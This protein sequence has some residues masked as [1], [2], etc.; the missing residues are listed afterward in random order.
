MVGKI[1]RARQK[2]HAAAVKVDSSAENV[3]ISPDYELPGAAELSVPPSWSKPV[4][5]KDWTSFSSD[6]FASTKIDP[7]ILTQNLEVETKS[8]PPI[9]K[10]EK[11]I[12]PKKEKAKQRRERWLEKIESLKLAQVAKKAQAKRKATPIVGDLQALVDALPELSQLTSAIK[13]RAPRKQPKEAVK[14]KKPEPTDYSKMRPV[15]KRKLMEEE[16]ARVQELM[17]NSSYKA[18][19]LSA[20]T[21]HLMKRMKA[22]QENPS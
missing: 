11:K 16:I 19:P 21:A 2:L 14:K 10:E 15:Q 4:G 3:P 18:N 5:G 1:K 13:R 8:S 17:K 12:L 9:K 20:V 22:E 7:E 6:I